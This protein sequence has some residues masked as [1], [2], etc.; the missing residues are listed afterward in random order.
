MAA[1][2]TNA[3][4]KPAISRR[5]L[6]L[7]QILPA[8]S[9]LLAVGAVITSKWDSDNRIKQLEQLRSQSEHLQSQI[10]EQERIVN[11]RQKQASEKQRAPEKAKPRAAEKKLG[12]PD[13]QRV[14]DISC[15]FA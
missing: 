4:E 8:L 13:S 12:R 10:N 11:Q 1:P 9:V 14:R 2:P 6:M 15:G 3:S 5:R 7:L